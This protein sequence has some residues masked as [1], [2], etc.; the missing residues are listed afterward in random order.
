MYEKGG[1][2]EMT[3]LNEGRNLC[4]VMLVFSTERIDVMI[5]FVDKFLYNNS[6]ERLSFYA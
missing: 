1:I 5:E 4:G 3:F 6:K 2:G